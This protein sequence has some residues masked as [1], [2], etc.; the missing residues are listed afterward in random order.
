MAAA[1]DRA[2]S[3]RDSITFLVCVGLS[4]AALIAPREWGHAV[5]ATIR[6]TVLV[7]A[8]WMQRA[9][10]EGRTSRARFEKVMAERDSAAYAAQF[11]PALR[12]EN[13]RLRDLLALGRRLEVRFVPAEVLHQPHPADGRT[14]L[15]GAGTRAGVAP[16]DPVIS[17][18]GL[19]GVIRSSGPDHSVALTWAHP[20]FRASAFAID[21][22]AAGIVAASASATASETLLELRGVPYRDSVPPGA[23]VVT[24]G[25]GGVYPH[26]IP[27]GTVLG[28]AREEAGWERTYAVRPA[29]N[30]RAVTHVLILKAAG[31]SLARAFPADSAVVAVADTARAVP[32]AGPRQPRHGRSFPGGAP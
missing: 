9:A 11:L 5:A 1:P 7:P 18:E 14:L 4:T 28:V 19:I 31:T 22:S 16:F 10:E 25:L 6:R 17:P 30:P 13:Q 15:L 27:V 12:A 2:H 3:R 21:G 23:L 26:G 32:S 8:L 24:S 20:E 29:A